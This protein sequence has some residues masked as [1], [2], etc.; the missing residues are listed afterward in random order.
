[1]N[2]LTLTA[3]VVALAQAAGM[4]SET[5]NSK[6]TCTVESKSMCIKYGCRDV[7]RDVRDNPGKRRWYVFE[8]SKIYCVSFSHLKH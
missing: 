7:K 4:F 8:L 5:A 2:R 3:F 1:M 6:Y